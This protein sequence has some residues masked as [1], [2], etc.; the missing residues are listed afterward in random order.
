MT[1]DSSASLARGAKLF[2]VSA[3]SGLPFPFP[4]KLLNPFSGNVLQFPRL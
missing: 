2:R 1:I 3:V 4:P